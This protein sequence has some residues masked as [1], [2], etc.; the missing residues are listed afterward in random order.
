M[1]GSGMSE[2][3]QA[4]FRKVLISVYNDKAENRGLRRF[5]FG[6][7]KYVSKCLDLP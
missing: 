4:R 2:W 7:K 5:D 6:V 1:T 3:A